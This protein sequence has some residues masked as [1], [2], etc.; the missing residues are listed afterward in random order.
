MLLGRSISISSGSGAPQG[1]DCG[2]PQ[3]PDCGGGVCVLPD[4]NG[5]GMICGM[6]GGMPTARHGFQGID[7]PSMP[8]SGIMTFSMVAMP[9]TVNMHPGVGSG[10]GNSMSKP[11]DNL[12]MMGPIQNQETPRQMMIA[13][14]QVQDLSQDVPPPLG[15]F[16]PSYLPHHHQPS[17]LSHMRSSPLH[18]HAPGAA[19]HASDTQ[20]PSYASHLTKEKQMHW[21]HV[22]QKQKFNT[23]NSL[24]RSVQQHQLPLSPTF[25]SSLQI[26]SRSPPHASLSPLSSTSSVA[27]MPQHPSKHSMSRHGHFQS[28]QNGPTTNNLSKQQQQTSRKHPQQQQ[29]IKV[30]KGVG[31]GNALNQDMQ[32]YPSALNQTSL[33]SRTTIATEKG[34]QLTNLV[35]NQGLYTG[36]ATNDVCPAKSSSA[37]DVGQPPQ[38]M[39]PGKAAKKRLKPM[40]PR[41][42]NK[43]KVHSMITTLESSPPSGYHSIAMPVIRYSNHQ[44]LPHSQS[45]VHTQKKLL[46]E[47]HTNESEFNQHTVSKSTPIGTVKQTASECNIS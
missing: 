19:N 32:M 34:D 12:H 16:I 8:S 11:H 1:P 41:S 27:S 35:Q 30:S 43:S 6:N 47:S 45:E 14:L 21:R 10:Q 17:Q 31:R 40:A 37:L 25:H 22:Q 13:D 46:N 23:S 33:N 15:G 5:M 20:Q 4:G 18:S 44:P 26:T 2:G 7:S 24:T 42:A 29:N 9:N 3:G 36:S 39:H 28:A 38:N